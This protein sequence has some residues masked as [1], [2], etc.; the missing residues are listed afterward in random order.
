MHIHHIY[1]GPKRKISEEN[2]FKVTLCRECHTGNDGVHFDI[3]K[4]Y[5]LKE[6]CQRIYETTHTHQEFIDKIN[7]NF[8]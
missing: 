4:D 6:E 7:K 8:L 3:E 2:G 1:F 5:A